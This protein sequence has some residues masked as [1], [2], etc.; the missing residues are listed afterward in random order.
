LKQENDFSCFVCRSLLIAICFAII[1]IM[2]S[3]QQRLNAEQSLIL[4][5]ALFPLEQWLPKVLY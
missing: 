3:E 1:N 5:S 4:A 2:I